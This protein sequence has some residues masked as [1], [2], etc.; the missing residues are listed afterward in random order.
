MPPSLRPGSVIAIDHGQARTGFAVA[1]ALRLSIEP[2]PVFHG[3]GTGEE[4]IRHVQDL[5]A[6]RT[7]AALLVGMPLNAEGEIKGRAKQVQ[8]FGE[9]LAQCMPDIPVL[10]RDEHLTTKEAESRLVEAGHTGA[11]RKA[12]KD[13]W[14]ALV[15]LEDW[16][17]AGEPS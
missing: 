5:V 10:F 7:V 11:A 3:S 2:L 16:V 8:A 17:R 12:R 14:S 1:D 13:S 15:L 6:E 4:L 9:R